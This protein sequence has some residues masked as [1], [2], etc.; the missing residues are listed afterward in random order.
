M[1]WA[2]SEINPGVKLNREMV[3]D[4]NGIHGEYIMRVQSAKSQLNRGAR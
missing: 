3:I 2:I 4:A 1:K